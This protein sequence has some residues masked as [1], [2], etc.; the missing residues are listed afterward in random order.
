MAD[1]NKY[2]LL[3]KIEYP[4]DLRKLKIDELPQVCEELRNDIIDEVSMNP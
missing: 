2:S 1:D 4:E 3:S